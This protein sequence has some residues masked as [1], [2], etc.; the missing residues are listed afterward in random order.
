MQS[1]FGLCSFKRRGLFSAN[2]LIQEWHVTWTFSWLFLFYN[3]PVCAKLCLCR[4]SARR[5]KTLCC[6]YVTHLLSTTFL[7]NHHW[8]IPASTTR[9]NNAVSMLAQRL[10]QPPNIKTSLFKCV[11]NVGYT[12]IVT[13]WIIHSEKGDNSSKSRRF[14]KPREYTF[15]IPPS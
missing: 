6:V 10:R 3:S 9:W 11:K 14:S 1:S 2:S 7:F 12:S 4:I 13:S 15:Q 8:H 5:T